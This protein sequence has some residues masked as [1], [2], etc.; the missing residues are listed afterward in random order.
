MRVPVSFQPF[1]ALWT[2]AV[3]ATLAALVVL[4]YALVVGAARWLVPGSDDDAWPALL[5]TGLA[6]ALLPLARRRLRRGV[7]RLRLGGQDDPYAVL[8]RL[9]QR[10][11]AAAAPDVV[12]PELVDTIARALRLRYVAI[13]LRVHDA[14]VPAAASGVP[15]DDVLALPL[16]HHG[17]SI[18]RLLVASRRRGEA[19]SPADR[20]LLD[21]VARQAGV[22]AHGV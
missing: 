21:D 5:A 17:A 8:S 22:A 4:V 10:L 15:V 11:D 2:A 13:E 18:G 7:D 20:A 19:F 14:W 12:L 1:R 3:Y 9:G 6:A 16:S